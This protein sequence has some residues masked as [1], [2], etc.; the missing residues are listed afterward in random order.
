MRNKNLKK[1]GLYL[2]LLA[3]CDY[4]LSHTMGSTE[5]TTK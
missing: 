1:A 2:C 4:L 5:K 3:M